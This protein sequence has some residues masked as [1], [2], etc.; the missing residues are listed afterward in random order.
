MTN[1]DPDIDIVCGTGIHFFLSKEVVF[2]YGFGLGYGRFKM[3]NKKPILIKKFN[4]D[5]RLLTSCE[6]INN[7][8]HG[9]YYYYYSGCNNKN[10]TIQ[11]SYNDGKPVGIFSQ[12][13]NNVLA[14]SVDYDNK[15]MTIYND[16]G[17]TKYAKMDDIYNEFDPLKIMYIT[18]FDEQQHEMITKAI[19]GKFEV[20]STSN[21][22]IPKAF[23][24]NALSAIIDEY[25]FNL[26]TFTI[27]ISTTSIS[28]LKDALSNNVIMYN[29]VTNYVNFDTSSHSDISC[30]A[31]SNNQTTK[32]YSTRV[33]SSAFSNA[34][35]SYAAAPFSM[36]YAAA[37]FSMPY[38]AMSYTIPYGVYAVTP[39]AIPYSVTHY[40]VPMYGSTNSLFAPATYTPFQKYQ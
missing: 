10:F 38:G 21:F 7:V 4:D 14:L 13:V 35:T 24:K 28:I 3:N 20:V 2:Y 36:P 11:G 37:P 1:F 22:F 26:L 33:M 23:P 29:S 16:D 27:T 40:A 25:I 15:N 19:Y 18:F 9:N 6:Y 32:H 31:N 39:Y 5:G 30:L 34:T 12:Y 8:R 17:I